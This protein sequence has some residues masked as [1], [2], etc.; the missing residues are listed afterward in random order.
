MISMLCSEKRLKF[1]M[2][3]LALITPSI[4]VWNVET[5]KIK[6]Y[7]DN[8]SLL[9]WERVNYGST[10]YW[11][12][13][14]SFLFMSDCRICWPNTN[15]FCRGQRQTTTCGAKVKSKCQW[16]RWSHFMAINFGLFNTVICY[17]VIIHVHF[18][19]CCVRFVKCP[20]KRKKL[21][22]Q[23]H[24]QAVSI[25]IS[26]T[27]IRQFWY[28][29]FFSCIWPRAYTHTQTY[30]LYTCA[31]VHRLWFHLH[32]DIAIHTSIEWKQNNEKKMK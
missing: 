20:I 7:F 31:G 30:V 1:S 29:C 14:M 21:H 10:F 2:C 5:F 25:S 18:C 17:S 32:N 6:I 15:V 28:V 8:K 26:Y 13:F 27:R 9:I 11:T 19:L 22:E 23:T 12:F 4:D 16:R 3:F 24:S